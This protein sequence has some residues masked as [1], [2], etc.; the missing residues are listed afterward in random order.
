M[1]GSRTIKVLQGPSWAGPS[2]P[3][4]SRGPPCPCS[5]KLLHHGEARLTSLPTSPRGHTRSSQVPTRSPMALATMGLQG[6]V[7]TPSVFLFRSV[8][9]RGRAELAPKLGNGSEKE[10]RCLAPRRR[11]REGPHRQGLFQLLDSLPRAA[12]HPAVRAILPNPAP[13]RLSSKQHSSS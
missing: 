13:T 4:A 6:D 3:R 11:R 8:Q 12:S 2:L 10:K 9:P 5:G 1:E 7:S